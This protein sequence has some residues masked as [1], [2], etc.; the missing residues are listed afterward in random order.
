MVDGLRVAERYL[1]AVVSPVADVGLTGDVQVAYLLQKAA[2]GGQRV[3]AG[4]FWLLIGSVWWLLRRRH[5]P[6]ADG[7]V[8]LLLSCCSHLGQGIAALPSSGAY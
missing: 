1:L 7:T 3:A 4:G 6:C 5:C 2:T 8:R